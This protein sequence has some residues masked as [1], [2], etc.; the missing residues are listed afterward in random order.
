MIEMTNQMWVAAHT[1]AADLALNQVSKN[2][3]Q[4]AADYIQRNPQAILSEYLERLECLGDY[5]TAG[6][7][8]QL[9]RMD[10][11]R[12]LDRVKKWP[13]DPQKTRMILGWMARLVEYYAHRPEEAMKRSEI[14]FLRLRPGEQLDGV[15]RER[16]KDIVWV[17]VGPGQRGHA[18]RRF[19]VEIG[20]QVRV[21]VKSV[22]NPIQFDVDIDS[23]T[24]RC[25]PVVEQPRSSPQAQQPSQSPGVDDETSRRAEEI[26]AGFR[27]IWAQ[28]EKDGK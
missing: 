25:T 24:Q 15:V 2:L 18:A 1:L 10:L 6:K 19:D 5:F 9:E 22:A 20:D 4:Q 16:Q 17:T 21:V 14:H 11:H 7:G 8:G 27:K 13:Q 3:V 26:L 12:A 28:E 23:V